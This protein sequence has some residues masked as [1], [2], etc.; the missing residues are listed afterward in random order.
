MHPK[1]LFHRPDCRLYNICDTASPA[2]MDSG[3]DFSARIM[4]Q[5]RLTVSLLNK[6][7]DTRL[8]GDECI[9]FFIFTIRSN[10]RL[11]L[12]EPA[13]RRQDGVFCKNASVFACFVAQ[14]QD[15]HPLKS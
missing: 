9:G 3:Y 6:Q 14:Q 13:L 10:I 2:V 15:R 1:M 12:R 5:N 8:S 11:D 7:P 4:Q